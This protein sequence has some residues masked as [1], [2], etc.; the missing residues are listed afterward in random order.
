MDG[1]TF[2]LQELT[3]RKLRNPAYSLRAFARDLTVSPAALSQYLGRK[4]EFS[5]KNVAAIA[6]HLRLS[7]GERQALR[8][9]AP[10]AP[11]TAR[12][13]IQEDEF[14][15]IGDWVS[16]AVLNLAALRECRAA[17]G[18]VA[19][20][21]GITAAEA[22]DSL[23]RLQRLSLVRVRDGRLLRTKRPFATTQDVPSP[24]IKRFHASILS[25]A[26]A[27]LFEVPVEK[28]DVTAI[29][30]PADPEKLA[31]AKALIRRMRHR[32]ADMVS[33]SDA[34]EVY[35]L[36]V[37]LFPLTVAPKRKRMT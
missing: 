22:Q 1:R 20:R 5:P 37:Q 30:M 10:K 6:E 24:A 28:R 3:S 12:D 36:A 18:W 23:E 11:V 32:I 34:G 9:G 25:K 29:V 13:L 2:L 33:D 17:P 26:S 14:R 27:S 21:L 15:L 16:L 4:R 31:K 7:P 8:T 35:V 19:R